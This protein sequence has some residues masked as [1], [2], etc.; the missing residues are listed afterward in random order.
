M[1]PRGAFLIVVLLACMLDIAT[2]WASDFVLYSQNMLRF[3]HGSRLA[4]QC[5]AITNEAATADIIVIQELM[6][7]G[8]PC[9]TLSGGSVPAGFQFQSFGPLG[10]GTYKEYYGFLYRTTQVFLHPVVQYQGQCRQGG[11]GVCTNPFT[12]DYAVYV[13]PPTALLFRVTRTTGTSF[14]IWIGDMH[15]VFG[16]TVGGRQNEATAAATFFQSLRTDGT[17]PDGGWPT[18]IA[19]DWNLPITNS[20]GTVNDGFTWLGGQN[21]AGLPTNIATSLTRAGEESSPYDHI[22]YNVVTGS[23]AHG[24]TLTN[25]VRKPILDTE[26]PTWRQNVSDHLGVQAEV[27]VQ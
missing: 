20:S 15:S 7:S 17:P 23:P 25:V 4:E 16:K 24:I 22:I 18:I 12:G 1:K 5:Q 3:G 19:G 11:N 2:A 21:A 10:A 27:T 14:D 9:L 26:W 8:Y 13:R 6:T